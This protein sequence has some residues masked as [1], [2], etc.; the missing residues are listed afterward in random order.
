VRRKLLVSTDLFTDNQVTIL[1][2][3][4]GL[5]L[6]PQ[7]LAFKNIYTMKIGIWHVVFSDK[8]NVA[9]ADLVFYSGG[10]IGGLVLAYAVSKSAHIHVCVYEAAPKISGGGT[11]IAIFRR[12]W[13]ILH[14]LG[15]GDVI[16]EICGTMNDEHG[17]L[18]MLRTL[19]RY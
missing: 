6:A 19:P 17:K 4:Q 9:N 11:G 5:E 16:D 10:G 2:K 8:T 13:L 7:S 3:R 15:L 12:T 1:H 14:K 18:F